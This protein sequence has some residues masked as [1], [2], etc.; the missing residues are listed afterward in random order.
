M[1]TLKVQVTE[2]DI[3]Q[4]VRNECENCPIAKAICR[5]ANYQYI[6]DVVGPEVYFYSSRGDKPKA[7]LPIEITQAIVMYDSN[8]PMSPM[9]FDIEIS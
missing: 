3:K 6:V 8:G 9:E 5:A 2:D 7:F 4:G 1:I